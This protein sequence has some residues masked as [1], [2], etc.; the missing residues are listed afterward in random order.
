MLLMK[1]KGLYLGIVVFS[2]CFESIV[3]WN[4][5][6]NRFWLRIA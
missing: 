5:L 1:I 4:N 3:I 6:I 2:T